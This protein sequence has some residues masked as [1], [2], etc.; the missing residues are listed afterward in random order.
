MGPK[1]I[2]KAF[3]MKDAIVS[4]GG[5]GF[6]AASSSG[7]N[8]YGEKSIVGHTDGGEGVSLRTQRADVKKVLG[9]R[10]ARWMNL[11]GNAGN[12]FVLVAER[13]YRQ[14]KETHE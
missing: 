7:I 12:V 13:S 1:E 10:F 8:N 14:N 6:A 2:A 4:G 9:F 5:I 3:E 11:G